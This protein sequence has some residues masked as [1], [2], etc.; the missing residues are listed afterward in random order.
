MGEVGGG[1]GGDGSCWRP[2]A[3]RRVERKQSWGVRPPIVEEERPHTE[4]KRKNAPCGKQRGENGREKKKRF[5]K[6]VLEQPP[7]PFILSAQTQHARESIYVG[8]QLAKDPRLLRSLVLLFMLFSFSSFPFW[9]RLCKIL[10]PPTRQANRPTVRV[11]SRKKKQKK[12]RQKYN[13]RTANDRPRPDTYGWPGWRQLRPS[14]QIQYVP[15]P[16]SREPS[17]PHTPSPP[18]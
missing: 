7:P 1:R 2:M 16:Q 4:S 8:G 10:L 12:P 9:L 13:I 18:K 5:K 14:V 6:R 11:I 17:N 3:R 15:H